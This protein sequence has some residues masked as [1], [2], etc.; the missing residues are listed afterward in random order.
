MPRDIPVGNGSM[1]VT[2]D[3]EYQIRDIYFR[4]GKENHTMDIRRMGV[5]LT[6]N[7]WMGGEWQKT[8]IKK[9]RW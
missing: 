4:V 5:W 8:L 6:A 2:F 1:L 3:R 7:S 9:I